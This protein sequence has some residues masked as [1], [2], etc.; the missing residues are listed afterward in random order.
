MQTKMM[1]IPGLWW[2]DHGVVCETHVDNRNGGHLKGLENLP[3]KIHDVVFFSWKHHNNPT[4]VE[5]TL[6]LTCIYIYTYTHTYHI[7]RS[8][9]IFY[10][11]VNTP[12]SH[13]QNWNRVPVGYSALCF[14]LRFDVHLLRMFPGQ[15]RLL[16]TESK[17][18]RHFNQP[19]GFVRWRRFQETAKFGSDVE[20]STPFFTFFFFRYFYVFFHGFF[21]LWLVAIDVAPWGTVSLLEVDVFFFQRGRHT[22]HHKLTKINILLYCYIISEGDYQKQ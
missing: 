9:Y 8:M 7:I 6:Q 21:N 1:K 12:P 15:N 10:I 13:Q 14:G 16:D 20:K 2:C 17:I 11:D 22:S 19:A 3:K 5:V 18:A 4:W